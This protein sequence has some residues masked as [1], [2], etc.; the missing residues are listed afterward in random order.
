VKELSGGGQWL[1][2]VRV[3]RGFV[4]VF[5]G[6]WWRIFLCGGWFLSLSENFTNNGVFCV[7][8]LSKCARF[9]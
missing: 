8:T 6:C 2:V 5:G 4:V 3:V 1:F 9:I 7:V